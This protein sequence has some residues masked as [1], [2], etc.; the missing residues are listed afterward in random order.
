MTKKINFI[1]S[2]AIAFFAL[3]GVLVANPFSSLSGQALLLGAGL[4]ILFL[5]TMLGYRLKPFRHLLPPASNKLESSAL[6]NHSREIIDLLDVGMAIVNEKGHLLSCNQPALDI[7]N[8]NENQNKGLKTLD[9]ALNIH[10]KPQHNDGYQM[11]CRNNAPTPSIIEY[12]TKL[13]S[14]K[15][16]KRFL[17]VVRDV[18]HRINVDAEL[19]NYQLKLEELVTQRTQALTQARD[20]AIEAHQ[21]KNTF[22]ANMTHELRTPLNAIIGYSELLEEEIKDNKHDSLYGE[23]IDKVQLAARALKR[24]IDDV[25]SIQESEK[26]LPQLSI[27]TIDVRQLIQDTVAQ[28]NA[29]MQANHNT[30]SIE[31]EA[32]LTE[33][34]GDEDKIKKIVFN[35]IENAMKFT[36]NGQ[37]SVTAK[38]H[39][40]H[41]HDYLHLAVRDQGV[42]IKASDTK[43]VFE[44]FKQLDPSTT[45]KHD[46]AGL[47]L[48][49]CKRFALIMGGDISLSSTP[50]VGST[51]TLILPTHASKS[52][53]DPASI[54]LSEHR[55]TTPPS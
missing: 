21:E 44:K 10:W 8:P 48:A 51:F 26:T 13:I 19:A 16:D 34:E 3:L 39:H 27:D 9:E 37:I 38:R 20:R 45:R 33:I 23:D 29:L 5:A 36:T 42:G 40:Q 24:L 14:D 2:S 15:N 49:L 12:A 4:L 46:G 25:L 47:G 53:I 22:L 6:S 54:R 55:P 41:G 17:I 18:T 30:L 43:K 7:L 52:A 32:G 35:L 1:L 28:C 50:G 31:I 11:A